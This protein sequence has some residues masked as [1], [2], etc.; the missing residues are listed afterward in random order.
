MIRDSNHQLTV[1]N[2]FAA[3]VYSACLVVSC[4]FTQIA[5]SLETRGIDYAYE[6]FSQ[7]MEIRFDILTL[8]CRFDENDS[9]DSSFLFLDSSDDFQ[10]CV[11]YCN[12]MYVYNSQLNGWIVKNCF[13]RINP[14]VDSSFSLLPVIKS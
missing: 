7:V 9:C 4:H 14:K 10:H 12:E 6:K 8:S 2:C 11:D 5:Q 13:L 3:S 1:Q